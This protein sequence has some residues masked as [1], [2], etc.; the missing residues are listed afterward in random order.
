MM[1][2]VYRIN[3][4]LDTREESSE[5]QNIAS[6]PKFFNGSKTCVCVPSRLLLSLEMQFKQMI[7]QLFKTENHATSLPKVSAPRHCLIIVRFNCL[8]NHKF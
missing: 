1:T 3:F 2:N 5:T 7:P 8:L 4:I 6:L